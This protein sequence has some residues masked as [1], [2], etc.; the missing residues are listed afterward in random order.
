[1]TT[2]QQAAYVMAQ[3]A[4]CLTEALGMVAA[5]QQA[6]VEPGLLPFDKAAFD[7]LVG[8]YGIHHNAVIGLFHP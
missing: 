7:D 8:K 6:V 2:E 1:M 3:A 4:A 5:N